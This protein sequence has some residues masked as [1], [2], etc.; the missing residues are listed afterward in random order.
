M[1]YDLKLSLSLSQLM[2]HLRIFAS[3]RFTTTGYIMQI[4]FHQL[5]ASEIA[6]Y[7]SRFT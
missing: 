1:Y 4:I 2:Y 7:N 3:V 5:D 6:I